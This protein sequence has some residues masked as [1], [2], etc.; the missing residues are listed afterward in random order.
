MTRGRPG[1]AATKSVEIHCYRQRAR[2]PTLGHL[3]LL[4]CRRSPTYCFVTCCAT[5]VPFAW[6]FPRTV[7]RSPTLRP[8]HG[9]PAK[10]VSGVVTTVALPT[11]IIS[12]GH[13]P[14][15]ETMLPLTTL[16]LG[17]VKSRE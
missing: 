3:A 15:S 16:A 2:R 12:T 7:T 17:V 8:P 1:K 13:T 9:P 14:A 5:I 11:V 4:S 10:M 6:M